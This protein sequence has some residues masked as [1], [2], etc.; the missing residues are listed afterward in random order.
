VFLIYRAKPV[1]E[2]GEIATLRFMPPI[3]QSVVAVEPA[4]GVRVGPGIVGH[5]T[6]MGGGHGQGSSKVDSTSGATIQAG[7]TGVTEGFTA[8]AFMMTSFD[9]LKFSATAQQ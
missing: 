4:N 8:G 3:S 9:R 6:G 7:S 1:V 5:V 2:E